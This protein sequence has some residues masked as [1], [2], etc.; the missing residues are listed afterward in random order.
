MSLTLANDGR[1][2]ADT[3]LR[4]L[5]V[6]DN[7]ALARCLARIGGHFGSVAVEST[8]CGALN[9]FTGDVSW[10]AFIVD[11][12]LPDGSGLE[13]LT[14]TRTIDG[15]VPALI[16]SGRCDRDAVSAAF[17]LRAQYLIKPAVRSQIESFL[18]SAQQRRLKR[19]LGPHGDSLLRQGGS[20]FVHEQLA[21][22]ASRKLTAFD[23][24]LLHAYLNG[25]SR[26]EYVDTQRLSLNTYK[27]RVRR[28]LRKLGASS[29][30]E[31]NE[32]FL[33]AALDERAGIPKGT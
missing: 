25:H 13:F 30:R 28:V 5:I 7:A 27:R 21:K 11:L 2:I 26:K 15:S 6:E 20:G 32:N 16:L 8:V 29:L 12:G 22:L 19:T 9:V 23:V 4:I 18:T 10:S 31:V 17:D 1:P 3:T 33:R 14:H 24:D